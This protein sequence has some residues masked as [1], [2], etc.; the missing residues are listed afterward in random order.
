MLKPSEEWL[1]KQRVHPFMVK[2]LKGIGHHDYQAPLHYGQEDFSKDDL[3]N[4][5]LNCLRYQDFFVKNRI[6]QYKELGY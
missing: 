2:Y 5:Y 3:L 1:K 6:E 4:R